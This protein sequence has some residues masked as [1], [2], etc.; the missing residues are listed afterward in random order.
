MWIVYFDVDNHT[1]KNGDS[2]YGDKSGTLGGFLSPICPQRKEKIFGR[3][4]DKHEN[5]SPYYNY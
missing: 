4:R 2:S 3:L 5:H 1:R